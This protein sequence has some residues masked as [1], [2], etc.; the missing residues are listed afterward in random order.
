MSRARQITARELID[1]QIELLGFWL[2]ETGQNFGDYFLRDEAQRWGNYKEVVHLKGLL[3]YL[4]AQP[5]YTAAPYYVTEEITD[6]IVDA[7]ALRN[8]MHYRLEPH[9][10]P[11]DTGFMVFEKQIYMKDIRGDSVGIR[12]VSWRI[13]RVSTDPE[14]GGV[15]DLDRHPNAS[16]VEVHFY[17][18]MYAPDVREKDTIYKQ[19]YE[20][21]GKWPKPITRF[22]LL[23]H[24]GLPFGEFDYT[25]NPEQADSVDTLVHA[26]EESVVLSP[27]LAKAVQS[28]ELEMNEE[29]ASKIKES[30]PT[31]FFPYDLFVA[32]L[33]VMNQKVTGISGLSADRAVRR[34]AE[35]AGL[36]IPNSI[37]IVTLRRLADRGKIFPDEEEERD[38]NWSHRWWVRGHWRYQYY[39]SRGT[40]EWIYI[41]PYIK[42]PE[43]KPIV[44]KPD[45]FFLER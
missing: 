31:A 16:G 12:A 35:R 25:A 36:T 43:N 44:P 28:G 6:L 17:T 13:S 29:L 19:T 1:W 9:Q 14:T 41:D 23:S 10:L 4:A 26:E 3:A 33:L 22:L 24:K 45:V 32:A 21:T 8:S 37:N 5:L 27:E 42:G 38:A 2:S 40:H 39:P 15:V 11:T 30:N 20:Q 34:R 7:A 18:D